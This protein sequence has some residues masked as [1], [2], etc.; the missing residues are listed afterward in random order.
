MKNLLLGTASALLVSAI[1]A[2]AVQAETKVLD[3]VEV[4]NISNTQTNLTAFDLV[5]LAQRGYLENQGIPSYHGLVSAYHNGN[6]TAESIVEGAVKS[7]RLD[8]NRLSDRQYINAVDA[9]LAS[10]RY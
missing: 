2:T 7:N 8:A 10:L 4:N 1:V 6:V 9:Q 3:P 5:V